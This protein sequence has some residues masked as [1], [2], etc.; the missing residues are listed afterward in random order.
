LAEYKKEIGAAATI[1]IIAAVGIG[2]FAIYGFPS[3][4][5]PE[6]TQFS[7]SSQSST[8][9]LNTTTTTFGVVTTET[10]TQLACPNGLGAS[11]T[12]CLYLY[13]WAFNYT[14]S[15]LILVLGYQGSSSVILNLGFSGSSANKGY[16]TSV[17][18]SSL[19]LAPSGFEQQVESPLL[20]NIQVGDHVNV[21]I[22]GT[23]GLTFTTSFTV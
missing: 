23:A 3:G 10:S 21:T 13:G 8:L 15:R 7:Q 14:S 17:S 22:S 5:R 9:S 18:D 11:R 2:I 6:G 12:A 4:S 16:N 20:P 19:T 1:A